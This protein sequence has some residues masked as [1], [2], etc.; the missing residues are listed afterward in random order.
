M[1]RVIAISLSIL[2][3]ASGMNVF[4]Q[5]R[6]R[7]AFRQDCLFMEYEEFCKEYNRSERCERR[8]RRQEIELRRECGRR[9]R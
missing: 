2:I 9:R 8:E 6:E 4:A 1:K 5:G 7:G 3:M